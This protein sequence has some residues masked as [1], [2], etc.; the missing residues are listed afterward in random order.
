[1]DK[2]RAALAA[3]VAMGFCSNAAMAYSKPM[4]DPT[5]WDVKS[6]VSDPTLHNGDNDHSAWIPIFEYLDGTPL[7]GNGNSS[8]F[9][10]VPTGKFKK[11]DNGYAFLTGEI[12]S[13]VSPDY[14]AKVKLKFRLRDG[15][16]Y[17][18][19]KK[20]LKS[21][22]YVE[23]GGPIDPNDWLYYDLKGGS[24]TGLGELDGL[25]LK[26]S[27]RPADGKFPTQIG[28]GA[29]GKNGDEGLSVW[30]FLQAKRNCT[31]EFCDEFGGQGQIGDFNV[32]LMETPIPGA[33]LLFLTGLGGIAM[34]RGKK[35]VK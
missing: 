21:S 30:F 17:G 19:A 7:D 13:Q 32:S 6:A 2:W 4:S 27:Q 3:T 29:N 1:M 16:G 34:R 24:F 33:A 26:F 31:S 10:F 9:D 5:V 15:P 22:A 8:D 28:Q 18:G 23:N 12:V 35:A 11:Y 20:Q 25:N 14:R